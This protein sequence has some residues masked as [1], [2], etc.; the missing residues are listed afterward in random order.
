MSILSSVS[1][2]FDFSFFICLIIL[3]LK[4]ETKDLCAII[5]E[6]IFWRSR[7]VHTFPYLWTV[8][9]HTYVTE[10]DKKNLN[11]IYAFITHQYFY[12]KGCHEQAC[13]QPIDVAW[14]RRLTWWLAQSV[15]KIVLLVFAKGHALGLCHALMVIQ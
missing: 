2:S 9:L 14:E 4:L 10:P 13:Y 5:P 6:N 7:N 11:I 15:K 3:L 12:W 1:H 8:H